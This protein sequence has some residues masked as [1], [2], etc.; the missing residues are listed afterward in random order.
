MLTIFV[1]G[2]LFWVCFDLANNLCHV[3]NLEKHDQ[4][5]TVCLLSS[6]CCD[7]KQEI[8]FPDPYHEDLDDYKDDDGDHDDEDD[9]NGDHDDGD[10]EDDSNDDTDH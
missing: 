8:T 6:H 10:D 7:S 3:H 2:K 9:E 4:T 1:R 5:Y